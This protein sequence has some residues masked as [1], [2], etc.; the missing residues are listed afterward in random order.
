MQHR[1]DMGLPPEHPTLPQLLRAVGYATALVGKWHLG[2]LPRFGPLKSGYES[3]YGH[4]RI[5]R[6]FH[7]SG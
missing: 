2:A 4:R 3:F 1:P 7:S 5:H 6:L